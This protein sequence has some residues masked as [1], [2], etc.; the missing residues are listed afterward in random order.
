MCAPVRPGEPVVA[1]V[2]LDYCFLADKGLTKESEIEEGERQ[3]EKRSKTILVTKDYVYQSIWAYAVGEKGEQDEVWVVKQL[4]ED[5]KT[6]GLHHFDLVM[7]SDGE[8][9]VKDVKAAVAEQR[10]GDRGGRVAMEESP[11]GD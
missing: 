7:K 9:S 11:V 4:A 5:L 2:A 10:A 1:K 6:L 8:P 3:D